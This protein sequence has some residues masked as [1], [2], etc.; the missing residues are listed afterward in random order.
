[1]CQKQPAKYLLKTLRM[2][3]ILITPNVES[4]K[5]QRDYMDNGM[6][7]PPRMFYLKRNNIKVDTIEHI[8]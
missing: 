3:V 6:R 4:G 2:T 5:N 8:V 7:I 1:M